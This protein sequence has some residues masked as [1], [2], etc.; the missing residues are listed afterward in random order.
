M[1]TFFSRAERLNDMQSSST[2]AT[3]A[4]AARLRAAGHD[5][6]DLGAG[7][8]DFPT[9]AAIVAAAKRALD[10]G[11]TKY[12]PVAGTAELKKA[13]A[14]A[15]ERETGAR[16]APDEI[17]ASAGGKQTLFNAMATLVN[18]GDEVII[19]APYWV[20]FPEIVAFTGGKSV[21]IDT[22]AHDFQLTAD[23]VERAL[24]PRTKLVILNSPS[25]PSG[26]VIAPD[27]VRKIAELITAR[28]VWAISDECYYQF[29]YPPH[30]PF[31]AAHL[32]AALRERILV[33][34]SFSKT[35]AM[36][37]WRVGYALGHR[38]WIAE[39]TKLQSH[40]TSNPTSF[41]QWAAIEAASGDQAS[42]TTMLAE[43]E[44]RRNWL[45]PAL[46]DLPGVTCRMPEG[47]F[48][49]FPNV[50]KVLEAS[51]SVKT[52]G[53][54][55]DILLNEAHVVVTPGSAFGTP[56]RLR[57]SYANSLE[58]IQRGVER[59]ERILRRVMNE[60]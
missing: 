50:K 17:I 56:G 19:P 59:M 49:A 2:M 22:E 18:P 3:T 58:A 24:T 31:S 55:A 38:D 7:E 11:R 20:T 46:N 32:P 52:D 40:S 39:M 42:V 6:I 16:Y 36:T 26:G 28:G 34:R 21:F 33:S 12:T 47:A 14:D 57:I 53:A 23:L 10:E 15:I 51:A 27:E 1:S 54:L 48:Y 25:N 43:Y 8:P 5:V 13:I 30:T 60:R 9:P 41:A 35:Y 37:G 44:R 4:A 45:V 29:T